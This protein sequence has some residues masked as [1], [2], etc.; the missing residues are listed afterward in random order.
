MSDDP[1]PPVPA[2]SQ[3]EPVPAVPVTPVLE[4]GTVGPVR[5]TA[6]A[7]YGDPFEAHLARAERGRRGRRRAEAVCLPAAQAAHLHL[8]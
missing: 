4:Y 3:G 7:T 2:P 5:L 1:T 6:V 8:I